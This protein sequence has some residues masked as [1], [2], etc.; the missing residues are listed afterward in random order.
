M[1][2]DIELLAENPKALARFCERLAERATVCALNREI[3]KES[4]SLRALITTAQACDLETENLLIFRR[5]KKHPRLLMVAAAIGR[6]RGQRLGREAGQNSLLEA[7][8]FAELQTAKN[9]QWL[10]EVELIDGD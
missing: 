7:Q 8:K 9:A 10:A 3:L 2:T 5:E 6:E 1:K 4:E